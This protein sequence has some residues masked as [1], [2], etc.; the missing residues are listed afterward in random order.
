MS[1]EEVQEFAR[2]SAE[3]LAEDEVQNSRI[4]E[5]ELVSRFLA[6]LDYDVTPE[7][8][9]ESEGRLRPDLLVE[10]SEGHS[11]IFEFKRP[12]RNLNGYATDQ[13]R[14]YL[15]SD[16]DADWGIV[17]NGKEYRI[18]KNVQGASRNQI[19][20]IETL[21]LVELADDP[22]PA[23]LLERDQLSRLHEWS[24][25]V[26]PR[27]TDV[28]QSWSSHLSGSLGP[29]L[30]A[31]EF[32]KKLERRDDPLDDLHGFLLE[33]SYL[34]PDSFRGYINNTLGI[35]D[36]ISTTVSD[37]ASQK[38]IAESSEV[39]ALSSVTH[40]QPDP[41]IFTKT[42]MAINTHLEGPT[43]ASLN[44]L[45]G[46]NISSLVTVNQRIL[47]YS[48][49]T[50]DEILQTDPFYT[51]GGNIHRSD[52]IGAA[53]QATAGLTMLSFGALNGD[54]VASISGS[55]LLFAAVSEFPEEVLQDY[56]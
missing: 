46:Q 19:L 1:L 32:Q 45:Q 42:N 36:R 18:Y 12:S 55:G 50:Y 24:S 23:R 47:R 26:L 27:E 10:V 9:I 8:V 37:D 22:E 16:F 39:P 53:G 20:H 4:S 5:S 44:M 29:I 17:T 7:P 33:N 52:I 38:L 30:Q 25:E 34:H 21:D 56:K 13:I 14:H 43:G 51:D 49:D 28:V 6:A 40:P 48:A 41:T 15:E 31:V 54:P 11:I 2:T 3:I 35:A